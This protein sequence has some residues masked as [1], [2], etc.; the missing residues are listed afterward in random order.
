[1]AAQNGSMR[2]ES[3][4]GE[5]STFYFTVPLEEMARHKDQLNPEFTAS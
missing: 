5:G 1:V 2:V 4:L 3:R